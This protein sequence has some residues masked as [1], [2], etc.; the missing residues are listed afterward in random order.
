[1]NHFVLLIA[2]SAVV[3]WGG[4]GSCFAQSQTWGTLTGQFVLEGNIPKRSPLLKAGPGLIKQD[5]PDESLVVDSETKGIA[6][7][8]IYLFKRPK[9]VHPELEGGAGL[10]EGDAAGKEVVLDVRNDRFVPHVLFARTDQRIRVLND[11]TVSRHLQITPI[12]NAHFNRLL[13]PSD[14]TGF[15]LDQLTQSERIPIKVASNLHPWMSAY[16]V[17]LDHPYA[18]ISDAQGKYEIRNLPSGEHVFF[19]WQEAIGWIDKSYVVTIEAGENRREP[20]T[21]PVKRFER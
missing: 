19:V 10:D 3:L 14:R 7:V 20:V 4:I 11:D 21:I 12:R 18:A 16:L 1:M 17:V 8:V 9:S 6:N 5:V 2:G 15:V 13:K